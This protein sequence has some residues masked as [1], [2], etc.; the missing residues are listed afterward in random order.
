MAAS[1]ASTVGQSVKTL[2]P[3]VAAGLSNTLY[4]TGDVIGG[5]FTFPNAARAN[6]GSGLMTGALL[7]DPGLHMNSFDIELHIFNATVSVT[8][9]A[10]YSVTDAEMATW[11]GWFKWSGTEWVGNALN[12]VNM[13]Q[14]KSIGYTCAGGSTSLFGVLVARGAV[15]ATSTATDAQVSLAVVRD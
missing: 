10:A 1:G 3:I 14:G 9:N 11:Q 8:D 13:Q 12:A 15:T 2:G 7:F 4:T 5:V 6:G